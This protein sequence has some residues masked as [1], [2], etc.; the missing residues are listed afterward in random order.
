VAA[1][2]ERGEDGEVV[3]E[4]Q[5]L[6]GIYIGRRRKGRGRD[7]VVRGGGTRAAAINGGGEAVQ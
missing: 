6:E 5:G 7:K 3:W 1:L 4:E 2:R